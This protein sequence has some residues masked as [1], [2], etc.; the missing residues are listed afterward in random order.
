[1]ETKLTHTT[2]LEG[3]RDVIRTSW[4]NSIINH[5]LRGPYTYLFM[6][7]GL[8]YE[9]TKG[10]DGTLAFGGVTNAGG[11]TGT[12]C[13]SVLNAAIQAC[14]QG[15]KIF[16]KSGTYTLTASVVDNIGVTIEGEHGA[17]DIFFCDDAAL[18]GYTNKNGVLFV[19]GDATGI[20]MFKIG[21]K[22]I[23]AANT[24][25][26]GPRLKNL[27]FSGYASIPGVYSDTKDNKAVSC[28]NIQAGKFENLAF[29]HKEYGLYCTATNDEVPLNYSDVNFFDYLL[30]AF[31]KRGL[32]ITGSG[33]NSRVEN[34]WSYINQYNG[35]YVGN[36]YD[37][38]I[39]NIMS[40]ADAWNN[41]TAGDGAAVRVACTYGNALI[42]NVD[43]VGYNSGTTESSFTGVTVD[44]SA[45]KAHGK[46]WLKNI[47]VQGTD[48]NAIHIAAGGLAGTSVFIRD[49]Y[50]GSPDTESV[51]GGAANSGDVGGAVVYNDSGLTTKVFVDGGYADCEQ[52]DTV[53]SW[54]KNCYSVQ[55]LEN[56]NKILYLGGGA[57]IFDN[58]T[59][60]IGF[61]CAT[62]AATPTAST[63]YTVNGGDLIVS[64]TDSGN[65]DASI[66]IRDAVN[67]TVQAG[68]SSF[69]QLYI[70]VGYDINWGNFSGADPTVTVHGV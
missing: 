56:F 30:F 55:N 44:P 52:A 23:G 17:G 58:T 25:T 39:R 33:G 48:S 41:A 32:Y 4:W 37:I 5:G 40:N 12:S 65:A 53:D 69:A 2:Y 62:D 59:D 28:S 9:A 31:N 13:H 61:S 19:D 26:F 14:S 66:T 27:G 15:A 70:P 51:Y 68:L 10:T 60:L 3:T 46:I 1:M 16:V 38:K 8:Y 35:V 29:Y 22:T 11:A 36:Y 47:L 18:T 7:N 21:Y 50:V 67:E 64:S 24:L 20:D 42:E 43:V 45:F 57:T 54:F 49:I 6:K 63:V 34:V